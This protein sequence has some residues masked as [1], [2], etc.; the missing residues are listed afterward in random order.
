M[1][2]SIRPYSV[3]SLSGVLY[4]GQ[5]QMN[6]LRLEQ[7]SARKSVPPVSSVRRTS[8]ALSRD[9]QDFL[10][11]YRAQLTDLETSARKTLSSS[12]TKSSRPSAVSN[13]PSVAEVSGRPERGGDRYE[14]EVER[15]A[16]G[17]VNRSV[18]LESGGNLPAMSGQLRLETETGS[19]RVALSAAGAGTNKEMLRNFAAKINRADSGVT[20]SVV[21]RNGRSALTLTGREGE[22]FTVSGTLAERLGID[23]VSKEPERAVY[24]V[25]KNGGTAERF[26]SPA[27]K[28]SVD[29]MDV[30]LKRSGKTEITTET[31]GRENTADALEKLVNSFNGTLKFLNDNA[32]RGV[33][34][35][36][37]I[38]R[39]VQ[40]PAS[41]R[42]M[43]LAGVAVNKDGTLTLDRNKLMSALK[44]SPSLVGGIVDNIAEGVRADARQGMSASSGSLVGGGT[45]ALSNSFSVQDDS[46][47][48]INAYN[49]SGVYNLANYF[50]VGVLM[51]INI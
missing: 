18:E 48:F 40:P 8:T 38:R 46:L 11:E 1:I 47:R 50:A 22:S 26:S 37:Q 4:S 41:E 51:N 6:R 13:D 19:Y 32:G 31:D 16:S 2:N 15:L 25:S 36:R 20:A 23:L 5:V 34:V 42:S 12:E 10:K 14:I 45:G 30:V 17:Q 33:G 7:V 44:E 43:N 27:N 21:E 35:L 29:G 28:V 49:R 9:T 39:M 3:R 24:S